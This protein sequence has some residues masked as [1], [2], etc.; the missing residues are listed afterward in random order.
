MNKQTYLMLSLLLSNTV[1]S[2]VSQENIDLFNT[3]PDDV[4]QQII[5]E[6]GLNVVETVP[7]ENSLELNDFSDQ[8]SDALSK[9]FGLDFFN[10]K[11]ATSTPLLDIPLPADY[12]L[13]VNDELEILLIGNENK[14][15]EVRIDLSGNV[16][17]PEVGSVSLAGLT[18]S[19]AEEKIQEMISRT[20]I[21]T[22]T[23]LSVS[24][25]SARK[26]SIIG[27]VKKPGSYLM[28][29][30]VT[31]SESIKYANG[32]IEESSLREIKVISLNGEETIVDFY[33]FLIFGDRT[34]DLNLKNGDTVIIG[35][36]D[37]HI[38]IEGAVARPMKYEYLAS[39]S[40]QDLVSFSQGF[41]KYANPESLF[42]NTFD[43]G[44]ITTKN[45]NKTNN[46]DNLVLLKLFVGSYEEL[47]DEQLFITGGKVRDGY[48]EYQYGQ[49]LSE[50][51]TNIKTAD[52]TYDY[53]QLLKQYDKS[54]KEVEIIP[55][56]L[57]DPKTY[58]NISLKRNPTITFFTLEDILSDNLNPTTRIYLKQLRI[59]NEEYKIPLI[60]QVSPYELL[61]IFNT[62]FSREDILI[63][64]SYFVSLDSNIYPLKDNYMLADDVSAFSFT[65]QTDPEVT[66]TI[67]GQVE[68]PGTYS[69]N[70]NIVLSDM[71]ALAGGLK[72]NAFA[73]GIQLYRE[74]IRDNQQ[75]VAEVAQQNILINAAA[76]IISSQQA[77]EKS[78]FES[79]SEL[80]AVSSDDLIDGRITGDLSPSGEYAKS[81]ILE[82][83]DRIFVPVLPT[84]VS[85]FGQ[86]NNPMTI[87]HEDNQTI[88]DYIDIAG[89]YTNLADKKNIYILK[90]SGEM[91]VFAGRSSRNAYLEAGDTIIILQDVDRIDGFSLATII[92]N[93]LSNSAISIAALKTI[94]D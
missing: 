24:K 78:S 59:G 38:E 76:K 51:V 46:V 55:F 20:F 84:T 79:L 36:T 17:I 64:K 7:I 8:E 72:N 23:S 9:I 65:V 30:Y 47:F 53:F 87:N 44:S 27:A 75:K 74:N 56:S 14:L 3:L 11:V 70:S 28:N 40:F 12:I 60:G 88:K 85:I 15:Y 69:I 39:D 67:L 92:S 10:F 21:G 54:G 49:M 77:T 82:D 80:L 2:Q 57:K 42:V 50:V 25:P 29:P 71:Y 89:G 4:K 43:K 19:N 86:V 48:L 68:N 91:E 73:S 90:G 6:R 93:I 83:G 18:L 35:S 63:D 33:D 61:N 26:I 52:L 81:L 32:L 62:V 66:I 45:V 37:R 5:D 1:L 58:E 13:S 94:S 16:L 31:I 41:T 22:K 34:V